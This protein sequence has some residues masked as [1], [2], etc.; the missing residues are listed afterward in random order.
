MKCLFT[1]TLNTGLVKMSYA[2]LII[3][4]HVITSNILAERT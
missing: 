4:C 3:D 1:D 2:I